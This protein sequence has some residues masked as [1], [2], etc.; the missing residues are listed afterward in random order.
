MNMPSKSLP[1]IASV[2]AGTARLTLH[3]RWN[4]G[5]DTEIDVSGI[6]NAFRLYAPLRRDPELFRQVRVGEHGTDIVWPGELDMSNDTLWRLA[7]EQSG[8]TVRAETFQRRREA[9]G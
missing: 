6:V 8:A 1:R 3:I 9:D 4:T 7:Q 2:A 5:D